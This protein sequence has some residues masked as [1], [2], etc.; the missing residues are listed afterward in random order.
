[1]VVALDAAV[2][3]KQGWPGRII[4][5]ALALALTWL[6]FSDG[7]P[8]LRDLTVF[9]LNSVPRVTS[10]TLHDGSTVLQPQPGLTCWNTPPPCSQEVPKGLAFRRPGQLRSGFRID[11]GP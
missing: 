11:R 9:E 4:A 7:K 1:M 10:V 5:F 8:A 3:S 2:R 6:P